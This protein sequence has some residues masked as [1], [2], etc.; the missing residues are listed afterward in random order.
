VLDLCGFLADDHFQYLELGYLS[1][2]SISKI[3][4]DKRY[5]VEI[6]TGKSFSEV[7]ILA[8]TNQQYDK[9]LFIEL[10]VQYVCSY[11]KI[12]SS[13]HGENMGRTCCVHKM[14]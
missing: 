12:A 3:E 2:K 4:N 11:M 13:E 5:Q 9:R 8:S 6:G 10:Q 7:L 1:E 14:F